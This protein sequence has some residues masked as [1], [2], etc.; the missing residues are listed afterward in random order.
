MEKVPNGRGVEILIDYAVTPNALEKLYRLVSEAKPKDGR[1]IAVFGSCGERDRGKRP[2]MGEIVSSY[3]DIVILTNED[4]YHEDPKR[5]VREIRRGIRN[6]TPE[7]DLWTIMDR[8]KAIRK[9]LEL[10]RPGDVIVV[11][12]KGA[13]ETM[14]VGSER[15][16]W[17]DRKVIEELLREP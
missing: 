13:E 8:R 10:A 14:A 5:I 2:I 16:P 7:A 15:L 9:A 11:T 4:P 6:K 17:N 12:G 3:A 1:V